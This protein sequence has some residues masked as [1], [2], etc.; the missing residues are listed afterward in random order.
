MLALL[1]MTP[2]ESLLAIAKR[3]K[4]L[5]VAARLTQDEVAARS[6]VALSTLRLFEKTGKI[7]LERLLAIA[8][9]LGVL[10][11]FDA[12]FPA[13]VPLTVAEMAQLH[14]TPTRKYGRRAVQERRG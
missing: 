3:A 10:Q 11:G 9:V 8:N 7:S 1:P 6:G 2:A 13:P 14:R 12:L 5:R 4:A